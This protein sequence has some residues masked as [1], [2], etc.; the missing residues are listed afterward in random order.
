[1][2]RTTVYFLTLLL[3]ICGLGGY[4]Q[5]TTSSIG[6]VV[7]GSNNE[8]LSGASV[9]ITHEPTGAVYNAQTRTGGRFDVLNIPPGGP[10]T[11]KASFVGYNQFTRT[12]VN[13]PLG[14]KFE[15]TIELSAS[16]T[17]L[18]SVLVVSNRKSATEK[19]GASTNISRRVIANMPNVSRSLSNLTRMTPQ[20]NGNSFA[21]MNYRFNNI[22]IDGSLF[23]NNFGRSGDGQVPG[24][25]SSAISVDAID[26][27]QVNIAPYDVRQAGFTGAGINAVT[28]RGTNNWYGT[29]YGFYRNQDFNGTKVLGQEVT[30]VARST[31]IYGGSIGGPII[32]N[33]LFFFV[34]YEQEKKTAPPTA[35]T[36][37]SR[38]GNESDPNR[39]PV[40]ATD[41]DRLK[42]HL[43]STY[44]YDPGGYEG[45]DFETD[46]KKFT[47][48]LDW[49]IS[50]R[51]RLT[52]R[53]TWSETND[54]DMVNASSGPPTNIANRLSNGRRG[55]KS[56]GIAYTGTNFKN[57]YKANSAVLELNSN[58]SN[59]VS[60]QLIASYTHLAPVRVPNTSFPFVDIMRAGDLNNVYI[61]FGTD[62]FSY[63]NKIDDKAYNVANNVTLNLGRHTV[64]L[65]ASFD[66]MTFENSFAAYGG[67]SYYRFASI[68]DFINDAAPIAFGVSYSPTNRTGIT[69]AAAKFAQGGLYMQDAFAVNEKFK[70]TYGVRFDLP[71][72]PYD[73]PT[74]T[75]LKA[76]TF[77]DEDG[78]DE[79]FD[80][81]KWPKSRLLVSPRVGFTYDPE[82]DK[83]IIVRG[84]TGIFTGRIPFIWL[85][86]QVGD[87][88]VLRII[89][90]KTG[91]AAAAIKFNADRTA[92]IP[93]NI[94]ADPGA[95]IPSGGPS[96]SAT[97]EDF[98]MPQTWRSNLAVDKKLGE[99]YVLTIEAL[100]TRMIN[101]VYA[102][103]ANLGA[104]TGR[105]ADGRPM[106][107]QNLN[108]NIGQMTILDNIN[109]GSSTVLTAQLS[110]TFSRNWEATVA[111]TYTYAQDVA[112]G[113][114]DQAASG[115][116]T[117]NIVMNPNKPEL[118]YSNFSIPHRVMASGSY[119]FEY[120][121]GNMATT[122]GFFY[123]G[124]SQDRFHYRYGA[125]INGDGAT[126]DIVFIPADP[127]TLN[128]QASYTPVS[129]GP[130]YTAQQQRDAF[131]AFVENDKYL[132]KHK[133][134]FMDRYGAT[135]PW[136]HSLDLRLL[137]DFSVKA[138]NK[139]HTMQVSVDAINF[140]NLLS[141]DWGH[142]YVY[143]FG[144]FQDQ[145]LLGVGS[146]N[147]AA[148]PVYTFNPGI[149]RAYQPDYSTNSTWGI[150][151]GLRYIFN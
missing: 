78:N 93:T 70:L 112:I 24:G 29:A 20:A 63:E 65:G 16:S 138:G 107:V 34:N 25:A 60:N 46:N 86:N 129:G 76:I 77:K 104:D 132:K 97:A 95:T 143:N 100:Y 71:F 136:F 4:A 134:Q 37:A 108:S 142:R 119:R 79:H 13:I 74:N 26:Q 49:N 11:I 28:R 140:L 123:T 39:S 57:N 48:R 68:D 31:K 62:L 83:S 128:F 131:A 149:T 144:S 53:Y 10:Y 117:N 9:T 58:F 19:V 118:G 15:I 41:L 64:T 115:W 22:T 27:V 18:E 33:K 150:Q 87:N 114:S 96:Y 120:M 42:Q 139:K 7:K 44:Q 105:R 47:G 56:G 125:N 3:L 122:I 135:L 38:P 110:K 61:S 69:P 91:A 81:S 14:E 90:Q 59:T 127:K 55:G 21:G 130:A 94:P 73:P 126:N 8:L 124:A 17:E 146:G 121:K 116:T 88:G 52:A 101:N 67:P 12:E 80:V 99:N 109:K 5:V 43:I 84:G 98:K 75:A 66:Y 133:G 103:N 6:G 36:V 89:E 2:R 35:I 113:T 92:Y 85:V 111:Y 147:T 151:L 40:L 72:Y 148:N 1:M 141:S 102:R 106:Y 145:A 82:G 137:Q 45:Y 23:N 50:N 30:N 51:H 32:K 54:D